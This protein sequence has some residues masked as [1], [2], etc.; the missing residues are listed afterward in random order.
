[1]PCQTQRRTIAHDSCGFAKDRVDRR[2]NDDAGV[3]VI[4]A[5]DTFDADAGDG[6]FWAHIRADRWHP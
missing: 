1:L 6:D 2:E 3:G 5:A 4:A